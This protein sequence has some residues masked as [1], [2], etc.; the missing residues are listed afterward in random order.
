MDDPEVYHG[1]CLAK[2]MH[3]LEAQQHVVMAGSGIV[4]WVKKHKKPILAALLALGTAGAYSAFKHRG[5]VQDNKPIIYEQNEFVVNKPRPTNMPNYYN[6]YG[7]SGGN[8]FTDWVKKHKKTILKVLGTTGAIAGTALG[9]LGAYAGHQKYRKG[10]RRAPPM[11][12]YDEFNEINN[13]YG[14]SGGNVFTDWVKKHKNTILKILATT[15]AV[16]G[17]ALGAYGA[18]K[19]YNAYDRY[20]YIRDNADSS[21]YVNL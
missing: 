5:K 18:R 7:M 8:A 17:T 3:P 4:D 21:G 11:S 12:I 6:G 20:R 14:M 10:Q 1:Y 16:A 15:G 13:G 2:G 9:A 19:G